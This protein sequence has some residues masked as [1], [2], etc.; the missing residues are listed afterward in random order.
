MN[1][2]L[3]G[4]WEISAGPYPHLESGG[5]LPVSLGAQRKMRRDRE[6]LSEASLKKQPINWAKQ[7]KHASPTGPRNQASEAG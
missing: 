5:R 4:G 6:G 2:P 7:G 3:V 1:Q